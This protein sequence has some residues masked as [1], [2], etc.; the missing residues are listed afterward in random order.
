MRDFVIITDSCCDLT[1]QMAE[2][3]DILVQPLTLLLNDKTYRNYLDGREIGFKE[4]YDVMRSG[5]LGSRDSPQR[6][7]YFSNKPSTQGA[8]A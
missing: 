5:S 3:L 6:A 4:F 2:E 7:S 1:A 8:M